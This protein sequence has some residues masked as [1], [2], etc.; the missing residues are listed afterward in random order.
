MRAEDAATPLAVAEVQGLYGAFSFPEKLLQKIWLRG[1]FDGAGAV[2]LDGH[3]VRVVHPGKWN[4]L[5]GPD[6]KGARLRIGSAT[7][8]E[9][10]GDVEVHLHAGDW[11]AHGHASDPAY[12]G[13]VLHVVLF[14]P[15]KD[16]VTVG[17]EGRGIPVLVLLPLLHRALEEFAGDEAVETLA[18]RPLARVMEELSPL[19]ASDLEALL[20]RQAEMRWRQKIHFARLRVERLGWDAACHQAALEILG[21]RFNRAPML[22]IAA[23]WPLAE[24]AA[25]AV[26]PDQALAAEAEAWSVQGVRPANHPRVR[27]AQYAAWVRAVPD[28]PVRLR[29]FV[30]RLP[31][32]EI[33]GGSTREV[34]R[35]HDFSAL[36]ADFA[37]EICGEAVGGTRL[38]NLICD[39]LIPL[40]ATR[41]ARGVV[42]LW[43]HWFPGD[44]PP[45]ITRGLRELACFDGRSRPACHGVAQGLLG[46]LI[47]RE[48]RPAP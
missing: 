21:F 11:R 16:H 23:R 26:S 20:R 44:L 6:F 2:T 13:V 48:G 37:R 22:R 30:R 34:R 41:E 45:V 5:G 43:H 10:A 32:D 35:K 3:P 29:E 46:W 18:Q 14:P 27:L 24:W 9:I 7:A 33:V 28:W 17:A 25:G 39:G 12:A 47:E 36:R 19:S 31:A 8:R 38:D 15:E 1:D 42:G 4:L 40:L